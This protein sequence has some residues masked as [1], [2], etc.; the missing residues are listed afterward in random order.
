MVFKSKLMDSGLKEAEQLVYLMDE[1]DRF[2]E[3]RNALAHSIILSNSS[4]EEEFIRHKYYASKNGVIQNVKV[5]SA[6][7][8]KDQIQE[9]RE[10]CRS[11]NELL[12]E[13]D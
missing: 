11:I 7:E 3:L 13:L 10:I 4:D 12:K 5:F 1:V 9:F 6:S 2:R 8:L